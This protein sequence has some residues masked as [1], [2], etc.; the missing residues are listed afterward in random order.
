MT[1]SCSFGLTPEAAVA[2]REVHQSQA[3]VELRAEELAGWRG[4]GRK[5][6]EQGLGPIDDEALVG[7]RTGL[8]RGKGGHTVERTG[9]LRCLT[10]RPTAAGLAWAVHP[11]RMAIAALLLGGTA[12]ALLA[13]PPSPPPAAAS[14]QVGPDLAGS[15]DRVALVATPDGHGY[16]IADANGRV[17][18]FGDAPALGGLEGPSLTQPV[19]G[20]AST[21][22]GRGYW[23]ATAGGRV[24]A[25]GDAPVFGG[26]ESLPLTQ[27]V[28]ELIATPDGRGYWLLGAD[29]GVFTFGD[30]VFRGSTG[31]RVLN[32]P[33]VGMAPTSS[34]HGYWMV[35]AD[36]GVF[37]FGDAGFYG[38]SGGR[39]LNRA[40][41]GIVAS[42]SGRG[43]RLVA[44]DGGL[45]TFGDAGFAGS[46][47]ATP[48]SAPVVTAVA[49]PSGGYWL[50]G[51]DGTVWSFGGA[52]DH[53]SDTSP[54]VAVGVR[55]ETVIDPSRPT[56]PR[57]P[58]AAHSGRTLVT[59]I[60]YPAAGIA[61]GGEL[62]EA[63]V[64]RAAPLPLIVFA[65]GFNVTPTTYRVLLHEWAGAGYVVAAPAFPISVASA[66]GP[67][68]ETDLANQPA[69]MSAVITALLAQS[70]SPSGWLSGR[71]DPAAVGVAG[72]SDGG[73]TIA[74]LVLDSAAHDPRVK[75]AVIGSGSELAMAGGS[76]GG[77]ANVPVL[78]IQGDADPLN[79]PAES[80]RLFADA[81]D[82][83]GYLEVLGGGH[84]GP[85]LDL[86][87]QAAAVRAAST[88]FFDDELKGWVG[89][90]E[91]LRRNGDAAGLTRLWGSLEAGK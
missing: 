1:T 4:L 90:L 69:D 68:S 25:F 41:V 23:L 55:T 59:T 65:H 10:F 60:F 32:Q 40:V 52:E 26:V 58:V 24:A 29:G 48:P 75:A 33:V 45:F 8:R 38:S 91:R 86:T 28:I 61:T 51:A 21:P 67:A 85:Y 44:A 19:V 27:P 87:P 57:G 22:D 89:G 18:A 62:P 64:A 79:A 73:S 3:G 77:V 30:A 54:S 81:R 49:S 34:G 39:P 9:G 78:V 66:A 56:P 72:Q 13:L 46:L 36:G 42:P 35:A 84:L 12:A 70:A 37:S 88:G 14:T 82:P 17:A 80:R 16:W 15:I 63:P 50:L 11:A 6:D 47:G 74:G 71:L 2:H 53:G 7:A 83:K 31:D 20:M 5:S 76:Y 43:Y